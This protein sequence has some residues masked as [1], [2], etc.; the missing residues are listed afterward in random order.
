MQYIATINDEAVP[1][2]TA[3]REAR[4]AS[5]PAT[6]PDPA[7]VSDPQQ[8]DAAA[9]QIPNP[10]LIASDSAYIDFVL[11]AA[12]KSWNIQ[13]A[14]VIA[15]PPPPPVLVNGVPQEVTMRQ[16]QL[17]L[18]GAGLLDAVDVAIAAIPGDAGRAAQIT[19]TKSSAVRRDNPLIA[20]L[21][22]A[23]GLTDAQI[24]GLFVAAAKL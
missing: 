16:A 3:A 19:W 21:S 2:I 15:P 6:V 5:L 10:E 13:H 18:L 8:P 9:P 23:L 24:D 20:Q 12:I 7:F 11:Q 22:A 17:A 4:N 14:A 1:G